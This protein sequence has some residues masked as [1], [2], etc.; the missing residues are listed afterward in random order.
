MDA[1]SLAELVRKCGGEAESTADTDEAVKKAVEYAGESGRVV[2]LGSLYFSSD[3]RK[4][5]SKIYPDKIIG[6]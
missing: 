4:S 6:R 3:V 1:E 2:S 5:C